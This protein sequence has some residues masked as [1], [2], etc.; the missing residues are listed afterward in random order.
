[1]IQAI[2]YILSSIFL[3]MFSAIFI[4]KILFEFI[5]YSVPE[6]VSP[7]SFIITRK[8]KIKFNSINFSLYCFL[9]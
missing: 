4:P 2:R 8:L 6:S 9:N 5:L 7:F 3:W 1:M